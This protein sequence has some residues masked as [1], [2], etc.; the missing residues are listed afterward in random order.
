MHVAEYY[1]KIWERLMVTGKLVAVNSFMSLNYFRIK[2]ALRGNSNALAIYMRGI[3]TEGK[4]G[5]ATE[6]RG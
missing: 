6:C 1:E 4:Q 3:H 2:A 5:A